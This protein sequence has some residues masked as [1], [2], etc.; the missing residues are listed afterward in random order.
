MAH[1]HT[2]LGRVWSIVA[3]KSP[4]DENCSND[5]PRGSWEVE[6]PVVMN[7]D[8]DAASAY[9]SFPSG[10]MRSRQTRGDSALM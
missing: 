8:D 10:D 5:T 6:S 9:S 4:F 7:A 3:K 2:M 1:I